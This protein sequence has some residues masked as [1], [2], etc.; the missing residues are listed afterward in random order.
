MSTWLLSSESSRGRVG[1]RLCTP[2]IHH[3]SNT[4]IHHSLAL[5]CNPHPPISSAMT[6]LSLFLGFCSARRVL[7]DSLTSQMQSNFQSNKQFP[8]WRGSAQP[9]CDSILRWRCK[10]VWD[11]LEIFFPF[12][13]TKVRTNQEVTFFGKSQRGLT[14]TIK[15]VKFQN[16]TRTITIQK[17]RWSD[18]TCQLSQWWLLKYYMSIAVVVGAGGEGGGWIYWKSYDCIKLKQ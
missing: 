11:T 8:R 13:F 1:T 18:C 5:N 15:A 17:V 14:S 4:P 2:T 6:P 10:N 9:Q 12:L 3:H 7:V 16:M